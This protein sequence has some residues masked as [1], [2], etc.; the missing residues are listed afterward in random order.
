MSGAL[1]HTEDGRLSSPAENQA[2]RHVFEHLCRG[3]GLVKAAR[4]YAAAPGARA[5]WSI[6]TICDG[7]SRG[8]CRSPASAHRQ[9]G[10]ESV[11]RP[12][13][14]RVPRI[15]CDD[16]APASI[17]V[18]CGSGAPSA[19]NG[20]IHRPRERG[21][22]FVRN[23]L[24]DREPVEFDLKQR[25]NPAIQHRVIDLDAQLRHPP[26]MPYFH[27]I[28]PRKGD[29]LAL[30]SN[31]QSRRRDRHIA[32]A[33]IGFPCPKKPSNTDGYCN[34]RENREGDS[35]HPREPCP[36]SEVGEIQDQDHQRKRGQD[37]DRPRPARLPDPRI[38]IIFKPA[39]RAPMPR[40]KTPQA[41]L[42]LRTLQKRRRVQD[43]SGR[44]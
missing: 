44:I 37:I 30:D 9:W 11:L 17:Q 16:R 2:A 40:R 27:Q 36:D 21:P 33:S 10:S 23:D 39:L 25:L 12:G 41:V 32:P 34:H 5:C 14:G 35:P 18:C 20:L 26:P 24:M 13:S 31:H 15:H 3:R 29:R 8:P 42:A 22:V 28:P 6:F 19:L 38:F 7:N 4:M 43:R 1:R